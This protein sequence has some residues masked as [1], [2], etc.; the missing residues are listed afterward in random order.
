MNEDDSILKDAN[1]G[2]LNVD[3]DCR[4]TLLKTV[5]Q[6]NRTLRPHPESA[7]T[8]LLL[9]FVILLIP[10]CQ[11]RT[12]LNASLG[13]WDISVALDQSGSIQAKME[14]TDPKVVVELA[15]GQSIEVISNK[16]LLD[17]EV[18]AVIPRGT[19]SIKIS[20]LNGTLQVWANGVVYPI[21]KGNQEPNPPEASGDSH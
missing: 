10:A 13:K 11:Q 18:K 7:I 8:A 20:Y 6:R 17:G 9:A 4:D 1:H 21:R 16:I 15:S 14:G 19:E 5:R 2:E 3:D 12:Y